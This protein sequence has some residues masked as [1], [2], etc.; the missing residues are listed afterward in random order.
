MYIVA[1]PA[2]CYYD[3]CRLISFKREFCR[4]YTDRYRAVHCAQLTQTSAPSSITFLSRWPWG[5]A[6]RA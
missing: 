4:G 6:L 2:A 1:Q 3:L 5:P